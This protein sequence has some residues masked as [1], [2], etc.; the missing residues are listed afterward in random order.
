MIRECRVA[1]HCVALALACVSSA[2]CAAGLSAT[3]QRVVKAAA[4]ETPR[5]IELLETL[6]NINSG[7]LNSEGV[8]RVADVMRAQLEPIGF[9]VEWLPMADVGRAGHLIARHEATGTG[10]NKGKRIL[11]IGHMDTVFER[12]S[13]F[14]KFIRNGDTAEGPGVNDMKDGLAIMVSALRAMKTAGTLAAARITIVLSGDEESPGKPVAISRRDMR[15]AAEQSDVALEF[16]SLAQDDGKDMG[17]I[18]R[19]GFTSWR[20]TTSA[21]SGHSSGMFSDDAGYG[22]IYEISRILDGF[23]REAREPNATFNVGMM[24]GGASA[25]LEAGADSAS[26]SGK[27]NIIPATAIAT[28]DLRTLSIEQTR[29]VEEKMR[30]VVARHLTGANAQIAFEDEYP[31]M[32]PTEGNRK[33]LAL[34]NG[35]NRDLGL[36]QM[37]ELD[38]LKRGAGD[39]AFVADRVDALVGF[40]AAGHGSHAPGETVDLTSF[41][42]QIKRT[43]LLI[44]RLAR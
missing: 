25:K 13:P 29:R 39:I 15:A 44:G 10:A 5:S 8:K 35:V 2:V 26:A 41:D 6:V 22:A 28:G 18:A 24:A 1:S 31:A 16:E 14:Q 19:R 33:V 11:L 20:L 43:A 42:R 36:P 23:R 4:A 12:D 30:S 37:G 27:S 34:L 3:E 32:A 21:K 38:P 17:T 9:K 7:S 40:G